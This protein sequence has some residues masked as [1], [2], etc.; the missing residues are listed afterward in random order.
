MGSKYFEYYRS[1]LANL[2]QKKNIEKIY[3]FKHEGISLK[4]V[5]DYIKSDCYIS[6]ENTIFYIFDLKCNR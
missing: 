2:I 4:N 3:F 6:S 1:F 5:T